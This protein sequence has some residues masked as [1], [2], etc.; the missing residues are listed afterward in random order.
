M[1]VVIGNHYIDCKAILRAINNLLLA[2][3]IGVKLLFYA[4]DIA[5]GAEGI[6]D[7]CLY[8]IGFRD[9]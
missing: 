6:T 1:C 4:A 9:Y 5:I 3:G 8:V 7:G 2:S